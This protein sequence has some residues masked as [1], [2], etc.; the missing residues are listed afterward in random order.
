MATPLLYPVLVASILRIRRGAREPDVFPHLGAKRSQLGLS[1]TAAD[2][3][4]CS[5]RSIGRTPVCV[6]SVSQDLTYTMFS[7]GAEYRD[8]S[9]KRKAD[10][11]LPELSRSCNR[12]TCSGVSGIT[13]SLVMMIAGQSIVLHNACRRL[14]LAV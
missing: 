2:A 12:V 3:R 13:P 6:R 8:C 9:L 1:L 5:E 11:V 14:F 4:P 10:D 7:T